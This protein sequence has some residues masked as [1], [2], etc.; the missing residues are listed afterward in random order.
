MAAHRNQ[1]LHPAAAHSYSAR[2]VTQLPNWPPGGLS[3]PP[4]ATQR[5]SGAKPSQHLAEVN[6]PYLPVGMGVGQHQQATAGG[7]ILV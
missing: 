5:A 3:A 4:R 7:H 1:R 6:Q 2:N